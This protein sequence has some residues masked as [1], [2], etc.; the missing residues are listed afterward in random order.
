[1]PISATA[2]QLWTDIGTNHLYGN[3]GITPSQ[4]PF[5]SNNPAYIQLYQGAPFLYGGT[6]PLT[7]A[8]AQALIP[9]FPGQASTTSNLGAPDYEIS[10]FDLIK[11][12][13]S[14]QLGDRGYLSVRLFRTQNNDIESAPG[15]EQ[16]V[17]RLR[18]SARVFNDVYVTRATQNTGIAADLRQAIGSRHELSSRFRVPLLARRSQRHACPPRRCSLRVRPPPTSCPSIR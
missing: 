15:P 11:L 6:M 8:Q 5:P 13:Y 2:V 14:R 18:A 7:A 12:G 16:S 4:Y 9:L 17:L 1:M 3:A 10:Q